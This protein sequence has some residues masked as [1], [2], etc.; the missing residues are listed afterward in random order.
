MKVIATISA[1]FLVIAVIVF[2][3]HFMSLPPTENALI[4]NF[5]AHRSTYE[6][7]KLYSRADDQLDELASWG[8]RNTT[9]PISHMPPQGG[10][11]RARFD[12]Y[13]SLLHEV[14]GVAAYRSHGPH[15]TL[16]VGMWG[17]WFAGSTEHIAVCWLEDTVPGKQVLS[18]YNLNWDADNSAG[19]RQFFFKK[20]ARKSYQA[21]RPKNF[22][23]RS[24]D[25]QLEPVRRQQQSQN[26]AAPQSRQSDT[27]TPR[28]RARVS[29]SGG[30]VV[31]QAGPSTSAQATDTDQRVGRVRVGRS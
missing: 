1:V 14:H 20:I 5:H 8:I 12:E 22:G 17:R 11:S 18:I 27:Q 10:F 19:Q 28:K 30:S 26:V 25:L 16:C 31:T 6:R 13:M 24:P 2:V 15:P 4:A 9:S 21:R 23:G 7:L 3:V 29:Q